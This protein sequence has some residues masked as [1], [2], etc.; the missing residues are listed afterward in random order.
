MLCKTI[1]K[2][3]YHAIIS[4]CPKVIDLYLISNQA[5]T[6]DPCKMLKRLDQN[7]SRCNLKLLYVIP[8]FKNK[9]YKQIATKNQQL[10]NRHTKHRSLCLYSIEE[11]C[12]ISKRLNERFMSCILQLLCI[13]QLFQIFKKKSPIKQSNRLNKHKPKCLYPIKELCMISKRLNETR[14]RRCI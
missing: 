7:C 11:P 2:L 4:K 9:K 5:L 14:R 13:I 12:I 6:V 8:L 3:L 1:I 10:F